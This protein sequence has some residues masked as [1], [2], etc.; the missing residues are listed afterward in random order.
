M[1]NTCESS[2]EIVPAVKNESAILADGYL[3]V[4]A[5]IGEFYLK[6]DLKVS[7]DRRLFAQEVQLHIE[8]LAAILRRVKGPIHTDLYG[9]LSFPMGELL[10]LEEEWIADGVATT[11]DVIRVAELILD[12]IMLATASFDPQGVRHK[13]IRKRIVAAFA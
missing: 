11:R 6:A 9:S 4:A 1:I 13:T 10:R 12:T 3:K 5:M 8:S 2:P 7:D